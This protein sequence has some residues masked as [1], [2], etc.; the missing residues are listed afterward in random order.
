MPVQDT[1]TIKGG[2]TSKL[3]FL[4]AT[5]ATG[6]AAK[7]GLAHNTPGAS[8]AYIREG[9]ASAQRVTL[10]PGRVGEW[11]AGSFVEVDPELLP[12]TYQVGV[13]DAMLAEDSTRVFFLLRFPAT[14]IKPIE[15]NLVAYDPQDA[16]RIG[17]VGLSNSNRHEFLRQALPRF[18]EKELALGR[19][20]EEELRAKLT[21]EKE[22]Q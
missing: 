13:P 20:A 3:L 1:H 10:I 17:L 14:V 21:S 19:Q 7:T 8:A 16:D 11:A 6:T 22:S 12:G 2:T 5:D 4:Y 9:Q 18:T 15:I